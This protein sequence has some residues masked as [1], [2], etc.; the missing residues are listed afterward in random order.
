MTTLENKCG[1]RLCALQTYSDTASFSFSLALPLK[2]LGA[3][4]GAF[5]F[6]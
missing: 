4:K 5:F 6:C 1:L 3:R 2:G